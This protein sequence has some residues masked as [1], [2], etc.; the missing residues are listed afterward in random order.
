MEEKA[1]KVRDKRMKESEIV[2]ASQ[3]DVLMVAIQKGYQPEF[4]EKM[5]DLKERHEQGEARKAYHKAMAAFK[6]NPPKIDKDKTVSFGTGKTSYT[7]AS[8]ANVTE[9]INMALSVHGLSAAWKTEQINGTIKVICTI[10]HELG[11]GENTSLSANPDTS[12]S[13]NAI[14]AVGSTISYLERYT[15]LALAGLATHDMDDDGGSTGEPIEYIN[16]KQFS[17]LVDMMNE[18]KAN[19]AKFFKFFKIKKL[20]ELPANRFKDAWDMLEKKKT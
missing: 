5:M 15:L 12:G 8:L 6:A 13:K 20:D 14:Q 11:H 18:V 9:K 3:N 16:K 2:P 1:L 10:T 19:Q 7:H 17:S 4:I